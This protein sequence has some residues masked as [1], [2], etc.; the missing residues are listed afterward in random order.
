MTETLLVLCTCP[1][2][3]VAELLARQLVEARLAAC[4]NLIK[5]VTSIYLWEGQVEETQEVQMLIKTRN[6][7]FEPLRQFIRQHHP[8]QVPEILGLHVCQGDREYLNW[9]QESLGCD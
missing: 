2:Q 8:Y 3:G 6:S 9:L 5:G 4:V 7:L 1:N